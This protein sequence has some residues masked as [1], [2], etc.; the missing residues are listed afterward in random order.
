MGD[1]A[2]RPLGGRESGSGNAPEA[3]RVNLMGWCP[4]CRRGT[5]QVAN[6]VLGVKKCLRC[7]MNILYRVEAKGDTNEVQ[8]SQGRDAQ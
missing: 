1:D 3:A 6:G 4:C 5:V 7:G 2:A 8:N